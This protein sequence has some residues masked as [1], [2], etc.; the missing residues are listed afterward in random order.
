MPPLVAGQSHLPTVKENV[1]QFDTSLTV[2]ISVQ[3]NLATVKE[4]VRQFD[5]FDQCILM[6]REPF[7]LSIQF[8]T[9]DNYM[10]RYN[11]C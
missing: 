4:N 6:Y 5:T 2:Y 11:F 1:R 10:F 8:D 3:G 7:L 9:F